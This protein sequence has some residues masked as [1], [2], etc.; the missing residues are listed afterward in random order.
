MECGLTTLPSAVNYGTPMITIEL[1]KDNRAA[2]LASLDRY[3]KEH[4]DEPVGNITAGALLNYFLEEIGPV[5]YNQ[6]VADVQER[7]S[8]RVA[9]IDLEVQAE[10]FG[11]WRRYDQSRGA[12]RK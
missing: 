11:Y 6:A 9:D 12:K 1:N 3:F 4:F 5:I 8:Q 10:A 7:L 2:A